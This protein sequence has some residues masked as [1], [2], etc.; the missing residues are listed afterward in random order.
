MRPGQMV[1]VDKLVRDGG[2]WTPVVAPLQ[3]WW[4][5]RK[6]GRSLAQSEREELVARPLGAPVSVRAGHAFELG[7]QSFSTLVTSAI[8]RTGLLKH[9]CNCSTSR[10][11][12]YVVISR[13]IFDHLT[14]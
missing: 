14:K 4:R 8:E 3:G 13:Q 5:R 6:R 2:G 10:G 1:V 11:H 7:L 9:V 12:R